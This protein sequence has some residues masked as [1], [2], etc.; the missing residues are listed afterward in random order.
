MNTGRGQSS[1]AARDYSTDSNREFG[2]QVPAELVKALGK[3]PGRGARYFPVWR[4]NR[5]RP[6]HQARYVNAVAEAGK[7]EFNIPFYCNVW[8]AYPPAALPE[9]HIAAPGIGYPSGGPNQF[10]LPIWK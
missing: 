6:G 5:F 10:M 9:R 8:L 1:G 2:E 4:M 3:R 7:R